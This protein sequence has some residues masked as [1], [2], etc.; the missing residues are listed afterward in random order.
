MDQAREQSKGGQPVVMRKRPIQAASTSG[1][2]I[3]QSRQE[4]G[5]E[6]KIMLPSDLN[7]KT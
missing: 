1:G 4:R 3:M 2:E 5:Y 7:P 6:S